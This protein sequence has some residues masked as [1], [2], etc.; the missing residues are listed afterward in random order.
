MTAKAAK[1]RRRD[2][3]IGEKLI[4]NDRN[5]DSR[6]ISR[7]AGTYR[8]PDGHRNDGSSRCPAYKGAVRLHSAPGWKRH[9][10]RWGVTQGGHFGGQHFISNLAHG[11]WRGTARYSISARPPKNS[12][13]PSSV[14]YASI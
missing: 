10:G 14:G 3:E 13:L 11:C 5:R 2:A 9:D 7:R 1:N 6:R 4:R 12:A 8:G